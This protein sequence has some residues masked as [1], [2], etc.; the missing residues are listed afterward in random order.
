ME[1]ND[2][3]KRDRDQETEERLGQK[4]SGRPIDIKMCSASGA[5]CIGKRKQNL[6]YSLNIRCPFYR[7]ECED[8]HTEENTLAEITFHY[9]FV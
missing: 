9:I 1:E 8:P 6:F 2:E 4:D 5:L 3:M 7:G